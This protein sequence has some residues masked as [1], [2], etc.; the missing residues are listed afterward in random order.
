MIMAGPRCPLRLH[1]RFR[2]R[3]KSGHRHAVKEAAAGGAVERPPPLF[4]NGCD[5]MTCPSSIR[6]TSRRERPTTRMPASLT[7]AGHFFDAGFLG[8]RTDCGVLSA[9]FSEK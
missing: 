3:E 9:P 5:R 7:K 1:K 8:N 2:A 4:A 6:G